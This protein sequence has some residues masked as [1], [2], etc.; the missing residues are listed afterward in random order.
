MLSFA[1]LRNTLCCLSAVLAPLAA[2]APLAPFL[3]TRSGTVEIKY[4]GY[5]AV[6]TD[7]GPSTS[8]VLRESAFAAGYMTS[9][10]ELDNPSNSYWQQSQNNQSISFMMYGMGE[11]SSAPGTG[12]LGKRSYGVGC[13]NA[14]F[15]C[16][17]LIHLDFYIDKQN[18]GT[19]PGFGLG[20]VKASDRQ[21]FNKLKGLTDGELLMSWVFAPGLVSGPVAGMSDPGFDPYSTTLFQEFDGMPLPAYGT[22]AYLANCV[23]GPGC[24]YFRTGS[25]AGGADFFCINTLTRTLASSIVGQNGWG[26]RV[27]NPVVAQVELPEPGMLALVAIGLLGLAMRRRD[28]P[29]S[30]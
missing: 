12:A 1:V 4:S 27:S 10:A 20:G 5:Q 23:S 9:I 29:C 2:A 30:P 15:G 8:G 26:A 22:G 24:L 14:A 21:G 19:N 3:L 16:D 13:T 6:S 25:N 28:G 17:G 7:S 11:A 18:G